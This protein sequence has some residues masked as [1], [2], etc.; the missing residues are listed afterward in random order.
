MLGYM[1]K[2]ARS[3]LIK[4]IFG[5][6]IVVFV[7]WGV[8]VMVS[9]GD[10][11]NVA[12]VVDGE[13]ISA[14]ELARAHERLQRTYR[15]LYRDGFSPQVA[16]QLNL[17]QRALDDLVTERLLTREAARLGLRVGDDEVRESILEI[18]AFHDGGRFDRNR[19]LA[20]LRAAR[21]TPAEFEESQRQALLIGKLESLLTDGLYVSDQEIRDLFELEA[22]RI[23]VA[24]VRVPF[25]RFR[26]GV[27]VTDEEVTAYYEENRERFRQPERVTVTYVP[28]AP[29]TFA[30]TLPVS[31]EAVAEYYETPRFDFET[32]E[33][34]HLR[35]ILLPLSPD[36]DDAARAAVRATAAEIA[37][38]A[39]DGADFAALAREHSGDPLS[40]E[41]GGDLGFVEP[42]TLEEPLERAAFGLEAG[43]VS[44]PVESPRGF[45]VLKVEARE[46]A[47]ARPLEEVREEIVRTIRERNADD[48]ARDALEE[49]LARARAGTDL[50]ELATA[51][52]LAATTSEP[53]AAGQP[54]AG[55]KGD[56]LVSTALAREVGEVEQ[57]DVA[58]PYYLFKVEAKAPSTIPPFEEVREA[59][60]ETLRN[61]KARDAAREEAERLLAAAREAGGLAGLAAAAE[62]SGSEVDETGLFTRYEA[63][64]KLSPAPISTHPYV[65]PDSAV[66]VALKERRPADES[67]LTD[68]KRESL[69]TAALS[70]K[71][72]HLLEAYRDM[73]RQRADVSI[74]P[75]VVPGARI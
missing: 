57:L 32:P 17:E 33:R 19:Y 63:L 44:D 2:N 5:M 1:R 3:T 58:P 20:T 42:G 24:F 64:P 30:A 72:A 16:A 29:E 47:G 73:L 51:R 10:R 62:A 37:G 23:N 38:R 43:G 12:A 14:Q 49:D 34:L 27:T 26:G 48:A 40:A 69:R 54:L 22:E 15:E 18:P 71:R 41:E 67:E 52:G 66:V 9:G 45:H 35:H 21:V 11:L 46:P 8:G 50:G 65:M 75:D 39:R 56:T 31:D 59:I 55:V 28:Y 70:R 13:P 68:E 36:A 61:E 60:V 6:I 25:S 53:T 74:N 4:V 7:F